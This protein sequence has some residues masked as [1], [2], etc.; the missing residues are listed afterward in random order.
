VLQML[1]ISIVGSSGAC[2]FYAAVPPFSL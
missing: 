1:L 2:S